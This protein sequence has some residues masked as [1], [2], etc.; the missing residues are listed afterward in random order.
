MPARTFFS[1]SPPEFTI[2]QASLVSQETIKD[3]APFFQPVAVAGVAMVF[4]DGLDLLDKLIRDVVRGV[5]IARDGDE[6][7]GE[8]NDF[9]PGEPSALRDVTAS[10][11]TMPA[12]WTGGRFH[13]TKALSGKG[14]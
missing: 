1:T 12:P 5:R 3:H 9:G 14:G 10:R 8:D 4:K 2:A 6:E 7:R 13:P 11:E